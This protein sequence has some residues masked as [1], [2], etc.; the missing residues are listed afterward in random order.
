LD[1]ALH[2]PVG[3]RVLVVPALAIDAVDAKDLELA[4]VEP[5]G[6][7]G[8]HSV[9]FVLIKSTLRSREDQD[10]RPAVTKGQQLHVTLQ[11]LGPPSVKFTMHELNLL[12]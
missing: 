1:V 4:I 12:R 9:V 10:L 6:N 5:I 8:N 11:V 3:M 2:A 7:A